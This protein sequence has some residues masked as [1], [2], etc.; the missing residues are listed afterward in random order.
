[1]QYRNKTEL[2]YLDENG[3]LKPVFEL[4]YLGASFD[5]LKIKSRVEIINGILSRPI[6]GLNIV[7]THQADEVQFYGWES[8]IRTHEDGTGYIFFMPVAMDAEDWIFAGGHKIKLRLGGVYALNDS[9]P[10]GTHGKG[11]VV[12]SFL[13]SVPESTAKNLDH[14][15]DVVRRF[16]ES[17]F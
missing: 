17:C 7:T 6:D 13:G 2:N 9:L 5:P 14:L 10:H 12:A 8:P 3:A 4:A 11:R 16:K 15:N 1:M